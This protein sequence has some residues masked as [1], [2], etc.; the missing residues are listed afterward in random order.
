MKHIK[1]HRNF[2]VTYNEGDNIFVSHF[3]GRTKAMELACAQDRAYWV[4]V[5]DN[6]TG[7][8]IYYRAPS[9]PYWR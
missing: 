9:S 1:R 5:V 8:E 3:R 4:Q 7:D 6:T 2:T